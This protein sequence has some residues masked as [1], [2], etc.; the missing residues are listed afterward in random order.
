MLGAIGV[1]L[2][3]FYLPGRVDEE[4]RREVLRRVGQH[5]S[6]LK[7][8]VRSAGLVGEGIE[9]RGLAVADPA[10]DKPRGELVYLDRVVL[11]CA[12]DVQR[13]IR[14]DVQ[15]ARITIRRPTLRVTRLADGTIDAA[16]LLPP[17][18]FCERPAPLTI[19][20]GTVEILDASGDSPRKIALTVDLTLDAPDPGSS[21]PDAR[22]L[23]GTLGAG[24]F[25]HVEVEGIFDPQRQVC[26]IGGTVQG[27]DLSPELRDAI[28]QPL[29]AK[30]AALGDL[31]GRASLAFRMVYDPASEPSWQ[32]AL[33]G[34]L[35]NGR[36]DDPRL[37]RPLNNI[38]ARVQLSHTGFSIDELTASNGQATLWMKASQEGLAADSPLRLEA[39]VRQLE[40][41]HQLLAHIPG[42][43]R[44]RLE[45][46]WDKYLPAGSI[47]ADLTLAYDGQ[48]WYPDLV[49]Q[50]LDVS[51]WHEKFPYRLD[52]G[53]G[54]MT[55]KDNR[56]SADLT[57]SSRG[58]PIHVKA[59]VLDAMTGPHGWF[60]V[61]GSRLPID[62]K[63]LRAMPPRPQ[64]FVRSLDPR[65]TLDFYA[66]T[67]R[68]AAGQPLH[69]HLVIGLNGCSI[70][71]EK[72]KYPVSNI[73][74]TIDMLD[75]RWT[76]QDLT[77]ENDTG[78]IL[79]SGQMTPPA[80]DQQLVL[81]FTGVNVP[82]DA[83][84][85]G[86]LQP[87]I[88]QVWNRL[89][90]RG[91]VDLQADVY[92]Q[93]AEKQ[94]SVSVAARTQP[95]HTSIEP[96]QFPYRVE[97]LRGELKYRDGHVTLTDFR[98]EHGSV[99]MAASGHCDFLPDGQWNLHLEPLYVDRL[100]VDR[101]LIPA[102]PDRLKQ[103]IVELKP[104]GPLYLRGTFELEGNARGDEP[105]R[106]RWNQTVFFTSGE[107]D[108]GV[109]LENLYGSMTVAGGF[110]G[111]RFHSLGELAIDSLTYKDCQFTQVMGPIW[112]DDEQVLLG[113][114]VGHWQ[115]RNT[116]QSA[117]R[118]PRPITA[119]VFGGTVYGDGSVALGAQPRYRMHATLANADLSRCAQE[120]M[121][122]RQNLKG[123]MIAAVD[124]WGIGR[125]INNLGGRGIVRL[126]DA[127]I[128]E[129]PVMIALLKILSIREPDR[130]AFSKSDIEFDIRGNYINF[131]KINFNGDA[132]S[133]LGK[134]WMDFDKKIGLTFHAVVGRDEMRVPV[135]HEVMGGASRQIMQIQ[136]RGD[137]HNP[138]TE[139]VALPF[140]KEVWEQLQRDLQIGPNA[141]PLFPQARQWM[142]NIGRGAGQ[143]R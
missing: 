31:R 38:R 26:A 107:I 46:Q 75:D 123:S 32:Y 67:W 115:N 118:K 105:I 139:K 45:Q 17:P 103:A 124:L 100:R 58:Q 127:D 3:V 70:S 23:K 80:E 30:L 36:I 133:L 101:D 97:R 114:H 96:V 13:L 128:Y 41:D 18:R 109:K 81:H 72:F 14:G 69:K 87:S 106:S 52:E 64:L 91:I 137:L 6:G 43:L 122:G 33:S 134:G 56:L 94:I 99:K 1:A 131:N 77:G 2:A 37:P 136:V 15:V 66:R 12:A 86:A 130:T 9:I 95:E 74:G 113:S 8:T 84:L 89:R 21:Q 59:E 116:A 42:P 78:R 44:A 93:Y 10:V 119:K 16:R 29:T 25:G 24:D 83:E 135:L 108:Y 34:E 76:F 138:Q 132:V 102:L 112:I 27:M 142:P 73:L 129:L 4:I 19:E 143:R 125:S 51:F 117:Q 140:V 35:E 79:C 20:D 121:A 5:Y 141:Q 120:V 7:V 48:T 53:K 62:D 50:C 126:R 90:P 40:L 63:L 22:A 39:K 110:D 111:R 88:Q 54:L 28:P 98:G 71:Y 85:R 11:H 57:A 61:R 60:E 92:Y 49:V 82:L 68:E 55:L 104:T 65:G 47:D